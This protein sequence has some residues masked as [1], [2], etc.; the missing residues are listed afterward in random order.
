MIA[1]AVTVNESVSSITLDQFELTIG[2]EL[3]KLR[4]WNVAGSC[5][6]V[7][8]LEIFF[9]ENIK[10]VERDTLLL[11]GTDSISYLAKVDN[12]SLACLDFE[13]IE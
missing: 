6:A 7:P 4:L 13:F 9:E 11:T 3:C 2:D 10:D 8:L 1:A 12:A 5:L